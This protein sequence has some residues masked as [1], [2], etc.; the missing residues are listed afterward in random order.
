MP[1][2]INTTPPAAGAGSASGTSFISDLI[3]DYGSFATKSHKARDGLLAKSTENGDDTV[4]TLNLLNN[5]QTESRVTGIY[6]QVVSKQDEMMRKSI[7]AM[8]G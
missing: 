3:N 5:Q 2:P 4:S 8:R 1:D 7:D 6:V